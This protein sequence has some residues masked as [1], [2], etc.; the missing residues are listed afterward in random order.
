M[1]TESTSLWIAIPL[2]PVGF[3]L[4]I[5]GAGLLVDGASSIAKRFHI[6]DLIIGLTIVAFGTSAPELVV[7]IIAALKGNGGIVAGNVIGSNIANICL[8]LGIAGLI[9]P[10]AFQKS[11][12][13]R[14]LSFLLISTFLL[15]FVTLTNNMPNLISRAESAVLMLLMIVY[16]IFLFKTAGKGIEEK[17]HTVEDVHTLPRSCLMILGGFAGLIVGGELIV[18]NSITVASSIGVSNELIGLSIVA[19]GTSLPELATAIVAVRKKKADIAVGNIIGSNIFNTSLVL[20]ITGSIHPI[21]TG[22]SLINDLLVLTAAALML[23]L[24]MF[25]GKKNRIDRWES[26]ILTLLYFLYIGYVINRG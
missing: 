14:D 22:Q 11:T 8:I 21:N 3:A 18:R 26:A 16:M 10:L 12:L 20:G 23:V 17:L 5:K 19:L 2:I 1:N 4:L 13:W 25:T 6:P 24:F 7:C 15:L 9:T